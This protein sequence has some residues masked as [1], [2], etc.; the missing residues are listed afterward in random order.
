MKK[1]DNL[2][3]KEIKEN[4]INRNKS[5]LVPICLFLIIGLLFGIIFK[6]HATNKYLKTIS[7]YYNTGKISIDTKNDG[8][9]SVSEV[10]SE[11]E[12]EYRSEKDDNVTDSDDK[13]DEEVNNTDD[14]TPKKVYILNTSSKKI[15]YPSCS[16]VNRMKE[17]NKKSVE[18]NDEQLNE[19]KNNGYTM[20]STCGGK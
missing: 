6:L 18:V 15:H 19:Y 11:N 13:T 9:K 7:D 14:G 16:V 2:V 4:T 10:F 17:E 8:Y 5:N 20:C 1:K 3:V 12:N